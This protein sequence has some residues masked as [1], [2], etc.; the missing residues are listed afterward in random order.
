MEFAYNNANQVSTKMSLFFANYGFH[1]CFCL[2]L[3]AATSVPAASDL[4]N[5]IRG[6]QEE[7]EQTLEIAKAAYRH[8]DNQHLQ[9]Q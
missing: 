8:H 6:T 1:S 4:I 3:P 9:V 2:A 5:Q 7:L